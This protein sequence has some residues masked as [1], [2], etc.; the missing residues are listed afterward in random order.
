M[1][2]PPLTRR[3]WLAALPLSLLTGQALAADAS[4]TLTTKPIPRF[5]TQ[6]QSATITPDKVVENEAPAKTEG[7]APKA[8]NP[9]KT[10]Q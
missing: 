2:I 10:Q 3:P 9:G 8:T 1:R 4:S 5:N 7:E 6:E